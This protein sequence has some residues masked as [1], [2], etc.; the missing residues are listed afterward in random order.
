MNRYGVDALP[1]VAE[2]VHDL[3]VGEVRGTIA[4]AALAAALADGRART[5]DPVAEHMEAPLPM[6]GAR[7]SLREALARLSE[8]PTLLVARG[9]QVAGI[10]TLHDLLAYTTA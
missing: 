6:I 10:L 4:V 9:G 1:V 3:R 8:E 2:P 7:T 5:D